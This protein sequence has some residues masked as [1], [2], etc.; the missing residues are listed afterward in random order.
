MKTAILLAGNYC[1]IFLNFINLEVT[2][3]TIKDKD[4]KEVYRLDIKNLK[5]NFRLSEI[6]LD[7]MKEQTHKKL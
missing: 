7:L 6:L 3:L 2:D 1:N 4:K 5:E